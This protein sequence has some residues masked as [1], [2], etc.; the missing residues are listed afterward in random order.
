MTHSIRADPCADNR[1]AL[2]F[3]VDVHFFEGGV[4]H[5]H[6]LVGSYVWRQIAQVK[7][8]IC[9]GRNEFFFC[10]HFVE[11]VCFLRIVARTITVV[12]FRGAVKTETG[13]FSPALVFVLTDTFF[14]A[15]PTITIIFFLLFFVTRTRTVFILLAFR[16][17]LFL[18]AVFFL[19][20]PIFFP[21]SLFLSNFLSFTV[22]FLLFLFFPFFFPLSLSFP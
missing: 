3:A 10:F 17:V 16:T 2:L 18:L 8:A 15:T 7:L 9:F 14:S 13:L 6:E 21:W 19:T 5:L 12:T 4:E 22:A 1:I 11:T 20:V